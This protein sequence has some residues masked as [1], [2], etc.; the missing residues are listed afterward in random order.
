MR[1]RRKRAY[2]TFL[3]ERL[4]VRSLLSGGPNV[5]GPF[6]AGSLNPSFG[7]GGIATSSIFG[8]TDTSAS[9][10]AIARQGDGKIVVAG[11]ARG[12][13][14]QSGFALARYNND[15]TLDTH[16]GNKGTVFTPF[17]S[18]SVAATASALAIEPD[19]KIVVVGT[20]QGTINGNS[21]EE[22]A[23]ARY[24]SDGSLDARFGN[25]GEVLTDFGPDTFS[26]A[27]S[28]AIAGNGAIVVA[29]S[30]TIGGNGDYA[31]ARYNA[32][33]SLDRSF[34][35]GGEVAFNF[36]DFTVFTTKVGVAL[37]PNGK[38]VLAGT[39]AS[40]T[41]GFTTDF[42]VARLNTNGSMDT[43]FGGDGLVTTS[44]GDPLR[45]ESVAGVALEPGT[46]AIVVAGT[47]QD[48]SNGFTE[49]FALARYNAGDGSLDAGFG[50]GGEVV[51]TPAP[52]TTSVA[53]DLAIQP[54]NGAILVT[55]TTSGFDSSSTFFQSL[56]LNRYTT[57]GKLDP[58]FGTGGQVLTAF[59]PGSRSSG[60]GVAVQL[61]GKI[62]AAG[63]VTFTDG[64]T[65]AGFGVARYNTNGSL[66][67]GF[68]TR[69]EVVTNVPGP[70]SDV[71]AGEAIQR[72]GK[73]VVVGTASVFAPNGAINT[74][75]ALTRFNADGSVDTHFGNNGS[76][77]TDFG[78]GANQAVAVAIQPD[79][80]IVVAGTINGTINDDFQD[81]GVA[82]Y[83]PDGTL[84]RS[85]ANGGEVLIDL[86]SDTDGT[87]AGLAIQPNGK[88]VVAGTASGFDA[89]DNFFEEIALARLN[90]NGR[91][92]ATFGTGGEVLTG[93]GAN[94]TVAAAGLALQPN[95]KIVV[96]GT[97]TDQDTFVNEFALARYNTNGQL[98]ASFGT[99]GE[100]T[101]SFG[102]G[103]S[104]TARAVAIQAN[105]RIVVAGSTTD[106]N[107]FNDDF[108]LARYTT[109]GA[110]DTTFGTGGL[111]TT[112]FG[113]GASADATG[114]AIQPDGEIV[115]AGTVQDFS[116]DFTSDFGLARYNPNGSLDSSFGTGGEV[117]TSF[118]PDVSG[119]VAGVAIAPGGDIVVVG[120][121]SVGF[122][123]PEFTLADYLGSKK[124]DRGRG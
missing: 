101:T 57:A 16:F 29:G 116:T 122:N 6:P 18:G 74:D 20:V 94:T 69:G 42:G 88:I 85:F 46:G 73:I 28:V 78:T 104:A 92:D 50:T 15:G 11:T 5:F 61:D 40:F 7:T 81:I 80:K 71:A 27:S 36:P 19:G 4:E 111:V 77:L 34:G 30:T 10:V 112:S 103:V 52:S 63:S 14:S 56:T 62:V 58:S 115:V 120:T 67:R 1:S 35:T 98:D 102:D 107:T 32:N 105:G 87:A 110:L 84:D 37:Q 22:F 97:A 75:F 25:G 47:V 45:V 106:L 44:F 65:V 121:T 23:L 86:G 66:D 113:P 99:G 114:L 124:K 48:P 70:S 95:G 26:S 43:T 2:R 31:V 118:G 68:G 21:S 91:L 100:V 82:R 119:T 90:A 117:R 89:D 54:S 51:T 96:A 108:A 60:A 39:V 123:N 41:N 38:V 53:T 64:G 76:V 33:G 79:G 49:E 72:D 24:N 9:D 59:T 12:V 93:F 3:A 13:N 8:P 17:L 109:T 55:G 83:N